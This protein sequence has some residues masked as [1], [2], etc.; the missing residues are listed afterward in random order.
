MKSLR[1][2]LEIIY[3]W[4]LLVVTTTTFTVA[5]VSISLIGSLAIAMSTTSKMITERL[6]QLNQ[7]RK[8]NKESLR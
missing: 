3:L 7:Q 1:T 5:V 8:L 6:H 2:Q 4:V